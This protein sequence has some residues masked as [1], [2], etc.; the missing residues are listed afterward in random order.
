MHTLEEENIALRDQLEAAYRFLNEALTSR[1]EISARLDKALKLLEGDGKVKIV[2]VPIPVPVT[3]PVAPTVRDGQRVLGINDIV[4]HLRVTKRTA[5]QLIESKSLNAS[6]NNGR[7][8]VLESDYH[9]Y[10]R[11]HKLT[12]GKHAA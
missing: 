6:W 1:A 12:N 7:W 10:L 4:A 11:V 2:P 9:N 5:R 8:E 3:A